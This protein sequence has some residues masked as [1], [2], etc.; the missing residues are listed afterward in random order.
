MTL[1]GLPDDLADDRSRALRV[2]CPGCGSPVGE[3]CMRLDGHPLEGLP[4][5]GKRM[6]AAGITFNLI[7]KDPT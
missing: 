7:P 3:P 2:T 4:A 1:P 6:R 5:H